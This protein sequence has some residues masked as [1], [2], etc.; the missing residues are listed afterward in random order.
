MIHVIFHDTMIDVVCNIRHFLPVV[1]THKM[2]ES[3]GDWP[4]IATLAI[5]TPSIDKKMEILAGSEA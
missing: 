4:I 1:A 5:T 2:I 3:D